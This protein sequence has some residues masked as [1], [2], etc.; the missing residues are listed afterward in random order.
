MKILPM[1]AED[2]LRGPDWAS[3]AF[4]SSPFR[5]ALGIILAVAVLA[6]IIKAAL[7]VLQ[8]PGSD[9]HKARGIGEAFLFCGLA[10][11][12]ALT[13]QDLFGSLLGSM[14]A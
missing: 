3:V 12:V 11:F 14:T 5:W 1:A 13:F 4:L 10:I 7:L 6:A 2:F 8:L 9:R